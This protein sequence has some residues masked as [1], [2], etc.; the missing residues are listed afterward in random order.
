VQPVGAG[1]LAH[2][3]RGRG[4]VKM[5]VTTGPRRPTAGPVTTSAARR[6]RS[7]TRMTFC[8]PCPFLERKAPWRLKRKERARTASARPPKTATTLTR[9]NRRHQP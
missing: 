6:H 3:G 2:D 5:A 9:A 8:E 4:W 7:A 1:D